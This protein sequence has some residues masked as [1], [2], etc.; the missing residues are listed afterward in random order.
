MQVAGGTRQA[1]AQSGEEGQRALA[2]NAPWDS[3]AIG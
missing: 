3:T 2:L 1:W